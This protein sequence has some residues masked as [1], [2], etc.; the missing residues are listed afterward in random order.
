[1]KQVNCFIKW[2]FYKFIFNRQKHF[3]KLHHTMIQPANNLNLFIYCCNKQFFL[4]KSILGSTRYIQTAFWA[5]R[6]VPPLLFTHVIHLCISLICWPCTAC[7][8]DIMQPLHIFLVLNTFTLQ[9]RLIH[10]FIHP[11]LTQ[12]LHMSKSHPYVSVLPYCS[13]FHS[14]HFCADL[15]ILHSISP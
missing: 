14:H 15:F 8:R 2:I 5:N 1:M 9:I 13:Y 3:H 4:V 7:L 10:S 12:T 6:N 11:I